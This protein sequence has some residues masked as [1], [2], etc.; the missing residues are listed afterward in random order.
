MQNFL[1]IATAS[2]T[3]LGLFF[4]IMSLEKDIYLNIEQTRRDY[5]VLHEK[6][7]V[8][9]SIYKEQR[10]FFIYQLHGLNEKIE[11]KFNKLFVDIKELKNIIS[12]RTDENCD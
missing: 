9:E 4:K 3:I 1:S 5:L 2:A 11:Q 8:N 12:R 7:Q 6:V 10:E